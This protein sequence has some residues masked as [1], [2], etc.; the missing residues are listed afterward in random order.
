MSTRFGYQSST[1]IHLLRTR[2]TETPDRRA[3][4]FL[5]DLGSEETHLTYSEL[6]QKARAIGAS[7]RQLSAEG[8][9]AVLLYPPGADFIV[10]L[11]GS[12]YAGLI[13]VPAYPPDP[14]RLARTLPRLRAIIQDSQA[15]VVLTTSFIAGMAEFLQEQAPDLKELKWVATDAVEPGLAESW[16]QPAVDSSTLTVLQYTSGSTGVPKGVMLS[17]GNLLHNLAL[18]NKYFR[19]REESVAVS[20]LPAYHDMGLIGMILVPMFSG[21]LAVLMSP[22][23]FLKQ[24]LLWLEAITRFKGTHAGGP[25]FGFDLCAKKISAE[26]RQQLDL[27]TWEVAFCGAEPIN[28]KTFERFSQLFEP[29]GFR[30]DSFL[31]CY[32]LA[33]ATLLVANKPYGTAPVLRAVNAAALEQGQGTPVAPEQPGA[34]VLVSSGYMQ[35]P[36]HEIAIV[37]PVTLER[38]PPGQIGEVWLRSPSVAQGY[39]SREET[40][41][42]IFQARI[43]PTGEGPFLRTGDLAFE[44]DSELFIVGRHKDLIIIRGRNHYPQDIEATVF[45]SHPAMRVGCTAAFSVEVE[46]E[47]RLVVVQEVDTRQSVDLDEVAASIRRAVVE[48]HEVQPHAVVLLAPG[49]I[50]KTTSGKIQRRSTKQGFLEETLEPLKLWRA[51]SVAPPEPARA[52]P[53][54]PSAQAAPPSSLEERTLQ[55]W[56]I[57]ALVSTGGV[58][59]SS[60]NPDE[61]FVMYGVD[62]TTAVRL[63]GDLERFTGRKLPATLLWDY[64]TIKALARHLATQA[65]A[66]ES[67]A[68]SAAPQK[69][70][71]IAI[72]GMGCRF[73]HASGVDAFWKLLEEGKDAI[74]E[75]PAARWDLAE[76]YDPD[77]TKPGKMTTRWGGFV[78]GLEQFDRSFFGIS[79]R[80]AA[81]MDPQQRLLLEVAWEA[82]ENAGLPA[83]QLAGTKAGVFIGISTSDYGIL[84][85]S[86]SELSDA[87]AGTGSALSIAA[88]RLSYTLDLRGPSFAVDTACS[89][90]LVAVHQAC[91]SLRSGESTVAIAGGVNVLLSPQITVNFSKAGFMAPDGRCKPFD[92]RANGYVRAEGAG[93]VILKPLS[94]AQA[95]GD[96]IYAVIRGSAV[97][98]DGRSNGLTA[99]NR[100]AQEDVLREAYRNA[101]VSPGRVRYVEA[102]GTGTALGDPIEVH[103]L[104]AVLATDRAPGDL[105]SIGSVKSNIG[106]LESAAGIAGL[107]KVALSLRNS[108]LPASLHFQ[109]PN[110]HLRLSDQPLRV[111]D[112]LERLASSSEPVFA[113]VSAFGFGGTNVHVVLESPPVQGRAAKPLPDST[114]WMLPLSARSPEALKAQVRQHLDFISQAEAG[115]GPSLAD[116]FHTASLRRSHLPHRL[117]LLG[118]NAAE[119]Q[120]H[121]QAL[122]SGSG[123]LGLRVGQLTAGTRPRLVFAFAGQGSQRWGMARTLLAKEPVFREV[124]QQ[125][126][127][128]LRPLTGTSLMA[129]FEVEEAR[130]RL[131]HTEVAQPALFALQVGLAALWRSFGIEPDAVVGHSVGEIAA[132][133]V[134]G[135]L[136]L[137]QAIHL[138]YHRSRLMQRATGKGKMAL[139]ELPLDEAALL[140]KGYEDRLS[141]AAQNSPG[142]TV[143]SGETAALTEL[144]ATLEQRRIPT[145]LLPVDYAFHSPQMEQLRAELEQALADLRPG[146]V[147]LRMISTVTGQ[148][149]QGP[150]LTASYWA[151]QLREPVSFAGALGSLITEG[152]ELFVEVGPHPVLAA[153]IAQI[154]R[155][156]NRS[157]LVLPSLRR[158]EDDVT[159]LRGS[160][161]ALYSQGREVKWS[162]L[163]PSAGENAALPTYPWQHERCWLEAPKSRQARAQPVEAEVSPQAEAD[164]LY[165]AQWQSVSLSSGPQSS[166]GARWLIV[167]DRQGVGPALAE[168]LKSQGERVRTVSPDEDPKSALEQCFQEEGLAEL[169]VLYLRSLDGVLPKQDDAQALRVALES[170]CV[171]VI[172]LLRELARRPTGSTCRLWLMTRGAQPVG[173]GTPR[174]AVAQSTLWG[175]G[176]T[177]ASEHP[178]LWG[179]MVDLDPG[180]EPRAAATQL[181]QA[182]GTLGAEDL[183][184]LRGGQAYASRLVRRREFAAPEKAAPRLRP[185]ATYLVTGGL[186]GVGPSIARWLVERGARRL[187]LMGRTKLPPRSKWSEAERDEAFAQRIRT[188]RQLEAMGVTVHVASVDVADEERLSAFLSQFQNDWPEI[189]GVIHAAGVLGDQEQPLLQLEPDSLDQVM[190][191][192]V[193]GGWVLH[194]VLRDQPL[195]FF[196]S[197]SSAASLLG[198]PGQAAYSAANAFLDALSHERKAV[199]LN[200]LSINWGALADAGMAADSERTRQLVRRGVHPMA[201]DQA[202]SAMSP[203]LASGSAQAAVMA[204]KWSVLRPLFE[205]RG[206]RPFFSLMEDQASG[207]ASQAASKPEDLSL[208]SELLAQDNAGR[209]RMLESFVRGELASVIGL[210]PEQLAFTQPLNTM[211][212][213]SIMA[214]ELKNRVQSRL[215]L[216]L[217]IAELIGGPSPAQLAAALL[218]LL[219]SASAQAPQKTQSLPVRRQVGGE[220]VP[221]S[222]AQERFWVLHQLEPLSPAANLAGI[223]QL[224]GS[225]NREALEWS[226]TEVIR[227]HE[228]LR[229]TFPVVKGHPVQV[230]GPV[231]PVSI[232]VIDLSQLSPQERETGLRKYTQEEPRR[233]Y[234]L[235]QGPLIRL[236]LLRLAENEHILVMA[237]H[238]VISDGWSMMTVIVDE[239]GA[240]YASR[241]S[242]QPSGLPE[243]PFQYADY[244]AWERQE[245]RGDWIQEQLAYWKKRLADAPEAL[246]L[247]TDHPRPNTPGHR[248]ARQ[249]IDLPASLVAALRRLSDQEG[250]TLFMTMLAALKVL[251]SRYSG[252]K[253]V[254]VGA[255]ITSRN[256]KELEDLIGPILNTLV[257]RT[258]L[259]GNPTFRELLGRVRE[260]M[261]GAYAHQDIP[262]EYLLHEL[263]PTRNLSRSPLFQVALTMQNNPMPQL[264]LPGLKLVGLEGDSGTGQFELRLELW[265]MPEGLRSWWVYS[266]ELFEPATISRMGKHLQTLLEAI[267]R[268]PAQRISEVALLP[269]SE[270]QQLTQQW[271]DTRAD[272]PT[273]A[274]IHHLFE[275]QVEKSPDAPAVSFGSSQ[276]SYR[277]LNRRS[278]QL[279]HHLRLLGVGPEVKVGLCVERSL[280]MVVGILGIL[281]AGG[282]Y[283]PLDAAY[284]QERLAFMMRDSAMAVLVTQEALADELPSQGEQLVCLD[285]DWDQIASQPEHNPRSQ[286]TAQNLAYV[287]YTSGS[288]GLPKGTLLQ[289]HG[290]CN[291]ALAAAKFHGFRPD[292][293]VL[294]FA[295]ASFDASVCEVFSTL[296]AGACL[297]MSTRDEIMPG[298][299]LKSLLESQ[300][301]TAVT[302][303]PSVLA[304]LEPDGLP[305]LETIISAGEA[306]PPELARRWSIGRTLLNAYGPTEITVCATITRG[307]V[308]PERITIGKPWDNVRT[309]ILDSALQPTPIGIPGELFVE[310]PGIAR[311]YHGRPELTAEKFIPHPF[312]SSPGARLYRTGDRARFLADGQIEYLGR[313]DSQVKLRGFRI[314][315]GEIESALLAADNVR[316]AVAVVREDPGSPRRL[317]AYLVAS[318]AD[319]IDIAAVRDS[320]KHRLPDYM[321]PAVFVTLDALPLTPN[322]KLDRKAL[323]APD[324]DRPSLAKAFTAPRNPTEQHL[325]DIWAGLLGVSRIGIHDNFFD[326]GGDSIISIQVI[327]RA[328]QVGIHLTPKQLFQHQTIAG[329]ASVAATEGATQDEQGPV[330]G[331]VP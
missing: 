213:D 138:V 166:S 33:E 305:L 263:Q 211:G 75:V 322:G 51:A 187:I 329:L 1:L 280:D 56:L 175:L 191:P 308:S 11:F 76:L 160:L 14:S 125:C 201:P 58:P 321:V 97:N 193:L 121:A 264:S 292:S 73:P 327:A 210:A 36:E 170:G 147:S 306:C 293:R 273:D 242:Q 65:P 311:G 48:S 27:S 151:R 64:P 92:S 244:A 233:P 261:L 54:A 87:Y 49:T 99:P 269:A 268:D 38:C 271:N 230:V 91:R 116:I 159:V 31:P 302:L 178:E 303:T 195:D 320:L 74:Q 23:D 2:A 10:G 172:R 186:G 153:D 113:G 104:G 225:L 235:T 152:H 276:W 239:L 122:L 203:L 304:Q 169:R 249:P 205:T 222:Y 331:S 150:E 137:P 282:A 274:C 62:S 155:S 286:V 57:E 72:I 295:A 297:C 246:D 127:A 299:P 28:P 68:V 105:C 309:F 228:V 34:R 134:A 129:E 41:K 108:A 110:P 167:S 100:V 136:S 237:M 103:A 173:E 12:L 315:L 81:R 42:E 132:A 262:F 226:F 124:I 107:M 18:A 227:R 131:S 198:L 111:Q 146:P 312:S 21:C 240:L 96:T 141:I 307:S 83:E 328:R 162:A 30:P 177:L 112:R 215:G 80:E 284:P 182:L 279:A 158:G 266:T 258:D 143:I 40:T 194:R 94:R 323:P 243:L 217:P 149:I 234:D 259:S 330:L 142:A 165:E 32:G 88:N 46:G 63:S 20:W 199:G 247:P 86:G 5:G 218:K 115:Q 4:T 270:H 85:M 183:L 260:G 154:L 164:W 168:A 202:M 126:D 130:S 25:N 318:P 78:E 145:R 95:D 128:L 277:E 102:H 278:N 37:D 60:I 144:L 214:L 7:L 118:R 241:L 301:I 224:A 17:H 325:A 135:A 52:E 326:M 231:V 24:P 29:V 197:F 179:G 281:K 251:L 45:Q 109:T 176:R 285:T 43:A 67:R 196:V 117:A 313:A 216:S 184:A 185:D 298:A 257:L 22:L 9:R 314:E 120:T 93:V 275:R 190:R 290:L 212:F 256:R 140:L 61:P 250:T 53:A 114:P 287:I 232:P 248:G 50:H 163:Y 174:V 238:H 3:Y 82:L 288:T 133:Y 13:A 180:A 294:Q 55:Q 77:P 229:T 207:P 89:S 181:A 255:P 267:V 204:V 106:H 245:L 254:S 15:T 192:K 157:G 272:F 208:R 300:R 26:A 71:P 223:L 200:G 283:I 44:R 209:Q 123:G 265:D 316:E 39:W 219:D 324:G 236:T 148:A 310:S 66:P 90:S 59:T 206:A 47:E 189:R 296:M 161:G 171:P 19:F 319:S 220:D 69:D 98:Q 252:Q 6:D 70:E 156:Q 221:L 79:P 188:I 16:K 289:H 291:T 84:Q 101:G 35:M 139:L 253:D 8:E 317:V 119:L